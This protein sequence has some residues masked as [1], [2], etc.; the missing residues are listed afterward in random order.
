MIDKLTY[1]QYNKELSTAQWRYILDRTY[2]S[3]NPKTKECLVRKGFILERKDIPV[4]GKTDYGANI[5]GSEFSQ[6]THDMVEYY[7]SIRKNIFK[8]ERPNAVFVENDEQL[9]EIFAECILMDVE[10][11]IY[12]HRG[13]TAVILDLSEEYILSPHYLWKIQCDKTAGKFLDYSSIV[14]HKGSYGYIY[15][16]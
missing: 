15:R 14:S 13:K 3:H 9:L 5:Y 2:I 16:P 7:M 1:E 8:V 4:I 10:P 11:Y 12:I 6:K